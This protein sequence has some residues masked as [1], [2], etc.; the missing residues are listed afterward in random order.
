MVYRHRLFLNSPIKCKSKVKF[1][2]RS[3]PHHEVAWWPTATMY[4][5]PKWPPPAS[6]LRN[7]VLIISRANLSNTILSSEGRTWS[8]LLWHCRITISSSLAAWLSTSSS[9]TFA[10][11]T[12]NWNINIRLA[13]KESIISN[14]LINKNIYIYF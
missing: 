3:A 2:L 12:F 7:S 9:S 8:I 4:T 5:N 11:R 6:T 10:F 14:L 13:E 1:C